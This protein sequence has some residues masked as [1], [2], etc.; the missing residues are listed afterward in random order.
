MGSAPSKVQNGTVSNF[1]NTETSKKADVSKLKPFMERLEDGTKGKV[2][3]E[4]DISKRHEENMI[5]LQEAIEY[6]KNEIVIIQTSSNCSSKFK[7]VIKRIERISW[8]TQRI[9]FKLQFEYSEKIAH[10]LAASGTLHN[11]CDLVINHFSADGQIPENKFELLLNTIMIL[12][13]TSDTSAESA[14]DICRHPHFITFLVQKM[15]QWKDA[16]LKDA[17]D[18]E[19]NKLIWYFVFTIY[20]CASLVQ[21]TSRL[22]HLKCN[23]ILEVYLDSPIPIISLNSFL[24]LGCLVKEKDS[25]ILLN[26]AYLLDLLIE[27]LS[28]TI[29]SSS[30]GTWGYSSRT[31]AETVKKIAK[32]EKMKKPIVEHGMIPLLIGLTASTDIEEQKVSAKTLRT[33]LFDKDNKEYIVNHPE[34]KVV[35]TLTKFQHSENNVVCRACE[36]ALWNLRE[37]LHKETKYKDVVEPF[38]DK[39][40][41]PSTDTAWKVMISYQ[42]DKQPT[43]KKIRDGVRASGLTVWM[44]VDNMEGSTVQAMA[45]AV[46]NSEIILICFSDKYKNSDNC[47]AEAEYAF[48]LKKKIIPLRMEKGYKPDGWLGFIIG[49]KLYHDF[50][51]GHTFE[52]R[53]EGLLKELKNSLEGK[54]DSMTPRASKGAV[55]S[56]PPEHTNFQNTP[57]S[58]DQGHNLEVNQ[59]ATYEPMSDRLLYPPHTHLYNE[60]VMKWSNPDFDALMI[61]TGPDFSASSAMSNNQ[62]VTDLLKSDDPGLPPPEL[63]AI[64]TSVEPP[65]KRF[66]VVTAEKIKELEGMNQS[67]ATKKN[68]KWG[69]KIL[70]GEEYINFQSIK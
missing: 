1:A 14:M 42:W 70:Q 29:L 25:T 17:L 10:E 65:K 44:D 13:N 38:Y 22:R 49:S 69:T 48:Q 39:H 2:L 20:N 47:R 37:V 3:S 53:M 12:E 68:T 21:N 52:S 4:K 15:T 45:H 33:L 18:L 16:H 31:L 59:Q 55:V 27:V 26:H 40:E 60:I 24:S 62:M 28:E 5:V 51:G 54:N 7:E 66:K 64:Q 35:E 58:M 6:L 57:R 63:P 67:I 23:S 61:E 43:V 56:N 41:D 36:G 30:H 8:P 19:R 34:L 46:E 11:L 9:H 32:M 50:G